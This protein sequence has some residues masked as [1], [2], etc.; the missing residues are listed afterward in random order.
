MF[1]TAPR[2]LSR[3][4]WSG[5]HW[6][7]RSPDNACAAMTDRSSRATEALVASGALS[8]LLVSATGSRVLAIC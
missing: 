8:F 2:R 4:R 1:C 7:G 6:V 3:R 5:A